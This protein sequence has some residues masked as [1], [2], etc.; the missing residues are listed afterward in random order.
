MGLSTTIPVF[1]SQP[2]LEKNDV[3]DDDG[4]NAHEYKDFVNSSF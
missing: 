4:D 1:P 2:L 3:T